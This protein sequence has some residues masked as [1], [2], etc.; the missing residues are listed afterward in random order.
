MKWNGR[1]SPTRS[2]SSVAVRSDTATSSAPDGSRPCTTHRSS[3]LDGLVANMI[4]PSRPGTRWVGVAAM[5]RSSRVLATRGS[6]SSHDMTS[7]TGSVA[8]AV[9]SGN[10]LRSRWRSTAVSAR[11]APARAAMTAPPATAASRAIRTSERQPRRSSPKDH[12]QTARIGCPP[13]SLGCASVVTRRGCAEPIVARLLA[14][15]V[16]LPGSLPV[17]GQAPTVPRPSSTTRPS[18]MRTMRCAAS[19]TG[20]SWVTSRIV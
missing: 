1:R 17:A 15:A 3:R 19:A 5:N 18:F 20:W 6:R 11:R 12:G 4:P 9:T 16:D 8:K 13:L 14:L 10:R 7:G 2:P